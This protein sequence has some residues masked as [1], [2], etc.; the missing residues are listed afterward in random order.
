MTDFFNF[1]NKL[2]IIC[3]C[4]KSI[5]WCS[6]NLLF[7][8]G[9]TLYLRKLKYILYAL[10]TL[11]I[12]NG[13][14]YYD[15]NIGRGNSNDMQKKV[16]WFL[17]HHDD[18]KEKYFVGKFGTDKDFKPWDTAAYMRAYID[19]YEASKDIRILRKLNELLKIVADGNDILTGKID[20]RTGR[21]LPGWRNK[22]YSFG[23][24]GKKRYSEMLTNALIAYPL[25][26]FA[27]IVKEDSE[28]NDEFG[29]DAN[30]YYNMVREL[31]AAHT[32]FV[33]DEKSPY[34]DGT[35]G[36]YFAYPDNYYENKVNY[37]NIEAPINLTVI[38]AEPLVEMYR[39]S[40]ADGN[41]DSA[42]KDT[43]T[44]VGNYIWHNIKI[45]KTTFNNKYLVWYYWP[46]DI[47]L[48]SR[49]RM[50]DITHGARLA[51]F[52]VS[53][54]NAGLKEQWTKK[55]LGY[56]ANTFTYS[57]VID[58]NKFANYIDGSGGIYSED[59]ATLFEWLE[60]QEYSKS[61]I[62]KSIADYIKNAMENQGDDEK[63]NIAVFA[64][65]ARFAN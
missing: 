53:L 33:N 42:Y 58:D 32:P 65:F 3:R 46:S 54:Y 7:Y 57:I 34:S 48:D 59:A 2:S 49:T 26:A 30:R 56:L 37:S 17:K 9:D 10:V 22:E 5:I 15:G 40:V 19:M 38:I 8:K 47:D 29:A 24:N 27:R 4:N 23:P 36:A 11:F 39:A 45:K 55:R 44:K 25:A 62:K 60:L 63:Y 13:F 31:Y 43:V 41:P 28:L 14:S 64:K 52:V 16:N 18:L 51:Q 61:Y 20:E 6:E 50:E 21:V 35:S 1:V 12:F